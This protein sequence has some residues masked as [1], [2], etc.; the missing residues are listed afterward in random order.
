MKAKIPLFINFFEGSTNK[1]KLGYVLI[2]EGLIIVPEHL[3]NYIDYEVIGRDHVLDTNGD[4]AKEY[5]IE[6]L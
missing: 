5:F 4:F 3:R 2:D 6:F 1:E